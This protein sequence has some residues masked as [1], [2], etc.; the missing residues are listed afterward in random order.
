LE[1]LHTIENRDALIEVQDQSLSPQSTQSYTEEDQNRT[2]NEHELTRIK[3]AEWPEAEFIVGNPPFL[4]DKKMIVELGEEYTK[5]IRKV[6]K[7]RVPGG[8]DLVTYWI[9]KARGQLEQGKARQAGLVATNSIRQ[10]RNRPVL[11]R[12]CKIGR[13]FEAR[14]DEPWVNEGAAVRVSLICFSAEKS[15]GA[16]L[17]DE[18]MAIIF[19]DLNGLRAGVEMT[20]SVDLTKAGPL[21]DN[22]G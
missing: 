14:S 21:K 13:I 16:S 19:A 5:T 17:D 4:G 6:Y 9:E 7:G 11:E 15:G 20:R 10:K 12:I 8:A 1:S 2:T 18:S 3:E 22:K